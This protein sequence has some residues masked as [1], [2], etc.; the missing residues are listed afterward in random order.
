[1]KT[2]RLTASAAILALLL[3][4]GCTKKEDSA[5]LTEGKEETPAVETETAAPEENT[6][7]PEDHELLGGWQVNTNY[8]QLLGEGQRDVF[9][10]AMEGLTGASYTPIQVIAKQLVSGTNYAFLCLE[11][12]V[13]GTDNANYAIVTINEDPQGETE[14]LNIKALDLNDLPVIEESKDEDLLGSWEVT[15]SG[16]PGA[17]TPES[18]AAL[19]D[20]LAKESGVTYMPI[21]LL[22]S[23]VVSGMNY[24]YL[25]YGTISA[26]V[27]DP[28][29]YVVSVYQNAEGDSEL[30]DAKLFDL[31]HCVTPEN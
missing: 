25:C 31:E 14:I 1:M 5:S 6:A 17:L 13:T 3:S 11:S 21:V 4:T 2:N 22:G 7:E 27:S 23:Q 30:T 10:K 8:S 20:A 28:V 24:K 9:D 16:K 15:G 12:M 26:N 19:S 29:L 18:E